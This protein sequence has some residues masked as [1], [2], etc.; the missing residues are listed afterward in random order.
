MLTYAA[1]MLALMRNRS[2][3]A[4]GLAA[5]NLAAACGA[6]RLATAA[7]AAAA[8]SK[9]CVRFGMQYSTQQNI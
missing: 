5:A 9:V 3:P 2:G 8:E 7:A 1:A 6:T 4:I